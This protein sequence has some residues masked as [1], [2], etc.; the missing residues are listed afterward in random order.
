MEFGDDQ[1]MELIAKVFGSGEFLWEEFSRIQ[2]HNLV[3]LFRNQDDLKVKKTKSDY[4]REFS[5]IEGSSFEEKNNAHQ[6]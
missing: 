5:E 3:D 4:L 1:S 6:C 2:A